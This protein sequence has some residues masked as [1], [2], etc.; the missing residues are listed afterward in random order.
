MDKSGLFRAQRT[1]NTSGR[2]DKW[3]GPPLSIDYAWSRLANR[4]KTEL[5][6][7]KKA[8]LLFQDKIFEDT[9][10]GWT[11]TTAMEFLEEFEELAAAEVTKKVMKNV[12]NKVETFLDGAIG[13]ATH[14]DFQNHVISPQ[15][16]EQLEGE[17]EE[18]GTALR[19]A[20][21]RLQDLTTQA[22]PEVKTN[23]RMTRSL[24]SSL[25]GQAEEKQAEADAVQVAQAR[26]TLD[27][28][29]TNKMEAQEALRLYR[30]KT[31][32]VEY[33]RYHLLQIIGEDIEARLRHEKAI[34][35][36]RG[37]DQLT[38]AEIKGI[39]AGSFKQRQDDIR[40]MEDLVSA[41]REGELG[42]WLANIQSLAARLMATLELEETEKSK[43]LWA[44]LAW[45]QLTENEIRFVFGDERPKDLKEMVDK[46]RVKAEMG[47]IPK[48]SPGLIKRTTSKLL[49]R[50]TAKA[51]PKT[52]E[53]KKNKGDNKK[54]NQKVGTRP[55]APNS[56]RNKG[57]GKPGAK[58]GGS[59]HGKSAGRADTRICY[60]CGKKGHVMRNCPSGKRKSH[61]AGRTFPRA[62]PPAQDPK[63]SKAPGQFAAEESKAVEYVAIDFDI[64]RESDSRVPVHSE[65]C[66]WIRAAKSNGFGEGYC[67]YAVSDLEEDKR[68]DLCVSTC[69]SD[70]LTKAG[71]VETLEM[72]SAEGFGQGARK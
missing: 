32:M 17:L 15:V 68:T 43:Q 33:L 5:Q 14:L 13:L 62:K 53:N 29:S 45:R 8:F 66:S 57:G 18:A 49:V 46:E 50:P 69:C 63:K 55:T 23:G 28:A 21:A 40:L 64:R 67:C 11:P 26:L 4:K 59:S 72:T 47:R 56:D 6:N 24:A 19:L 37:E 10:E 70:A 48:F 20:Q 22:R 31:V 52:E 34:R 38:W 39:V 25:G 3:W 60:I 12:K 58:Q 51:S 7:G 27:E 9:G 36:A 2:E 41:R 1:R 65:T 42:T 16:A 61:G 54:G 35:E 44:D 71:L 30:R